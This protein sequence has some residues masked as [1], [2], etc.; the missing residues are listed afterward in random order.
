[1][2]KSSI[3]E[4]WLLAELVS[5]PSTSG[6]ETDVARLSEETARRAGL[7]ARRD[8]LG[9]MIE[10]SG[11][12]AGP[13]LALVSHLDTVPPGGGAV[14]PFNRRSKAGG[15]T[16]AARGCK[17]LGSG[18]AR[19]RRG[20]GRGRWAFA[21]PLARRPRLLR[22]NPRHDDAAPRPHS[23][24]VDAAVVGEP[25]NLDLAIAQR[26]VIWLDLVARGTQI[27]AGRADGEGFVNAIVTLAR[28][29]VALGDVGAGRPHPVLGDPTITPTMIEAGVGRNVTPSVAR[30][31]LD[32]R[33]TPRGPTRS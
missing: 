22:G 18:H 17:G 1:M 29:L 21:R 5:I 28:D 30:A 8:E 10:V 24:T 3:D 2:S 12:T 6:S 23:G 13:T 15:Y 11:R 19:G 20:R 4:V 33:T 7:D 31:S 16:A 26:G 9:V 14:T 27:H 25:T 32:V